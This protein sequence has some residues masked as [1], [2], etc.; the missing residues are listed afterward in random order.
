MVSHTLYSRSTQTEEDD[1]FPDEN[2]SLKAEELAKEEDSKMS[3]ERELSAAGIKGAA[4]GPHHRHLKIGKHSVPLSPLTGL[5]A[6]GSVALVAVGILKFVAPKRKL[7][8]KKN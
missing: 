7:A 4:A 2:E 3:K 8:P 5:L 1:E 6:L